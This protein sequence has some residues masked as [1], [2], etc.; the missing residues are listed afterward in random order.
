[1][2]QP[3]PAPIREATSSVASPAEM[4]ESFYGP[5]IFEPCTRV[6]LEKVPPRPGEAVLDLACGTGQVARRAASMVGDEG[7]VVA[8]DVNP[9]MLEVG[10]S[11]PRPPGAPV[12][13]VEGDAVSLDLPDRS[14]DLVLCQQG[15]QFFPDRA[16]AL[17]QVHRVLRPG[18]RIGVAVWQGTDRHPLYAAMTAAEARHLGDLGG[19]EG[20]LLVPFSLG[21]EG[22]LAG[23]IE[24]SGFSG[25]QIHKASIQARFPDPD[26]WVRN[27]QLAYAAV[28][29]AFEKDPKAFESFVRGI[30]NDI[31]HLVREHTEGDEVVVPM[32]A[33][34]ASARAAW[35]AS[36]EMR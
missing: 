3:T 35:C 34:I 14:F 30:E 4:Y 22:Q 11:L 28:I 21:D 9:G 10:R 36:P 27:M 24:E 15:L 1:M 29:P 13:W 18:G 31:G 12:E 5:A 26:T 2:S 32:H 33:L 20:D 7:R 25:V 17:E 6:L 23:L 8:L 16:C 19:E